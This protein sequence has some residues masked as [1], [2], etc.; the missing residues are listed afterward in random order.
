M[1]GRPSGRRGIALVLAS[2]ILS[3]FL[4]VSFLVVSVSGSFARLAAG[5]AVR[6]GAVLAAASGMEYAAGRLARGGGP[7]SAAWDRRLR[8]GGSRF[9]ARADPLDGRIP[10][11]A[12]YLRSDDLAGLILWPNDLPNGEPDCRDTGIQYHLAVA[13][14]LNNLGWICGVEARRW[15]IPAGDLAG[16]PGEP[17]EISWL[18]MDLLGNRP[19]GGYRDWGQ[20]EKTLLDLGV[21]YT[22]ADVERIRPFVD[23]STE[24]AISASR[25]SGAEGDD[26]PPYIPVN[27][28]AAPIE[29]LESLFRYAGAKRALSSFPQLKLEAG[30]VKYGRSGPPGAPATRTYAGAPLVL[31]PDEAKALAACLADLRAS[32]PLSWQGIHREFSGKAHLLFSREW[33]E[34]AGRNLLRRIW[35]QEKAD[36]AFQVIAID[37]YP[38]LFPNHGG[39]TAWAGRGIDRFPDDTGFPG[40]AGFQLLAMAPYE[41]NMTRVALPLAG[42]DDRSGVY[43]PWPQWEWG[44]TFAP[45]EGASLTIRPQGGA[46]GPPVRFGVSCSGWSVD[47][48]Q[49]IEGDLSVLER[50]DFASQEDFDNLLGGG[51]LRRR[52][53]GTIDPDPPARYEWR[54][55]NEPHDRL[56]DGAL[57][58]YGD[59]SPGTL[60]PGR[61]PGDLRVQARVA[62]L[63]IYNRRSL[64]FGAAGAAGVSH[65][66]GAVTLARREAGPLGAAFYWPFSQ[67]F[68]GSP[69]FAEGDA[70][71]ET[72]HPLLRAPP[73]LPMSVLAWSAAANPYG[74]NALVIDGKMSSFE[75][76]GIDEGAPFG[77]FSLEFWMGMDGYFRL[78]GEGGHCVSVGLCRAMS[79]GTPGSSLDLRVQWQDDSAVAQTSNTNWFFPDGPEGALLDRHVVLTTAPSGASGHRFRLFVDGTDLSATGPMIHDHPHSLKGTW[80]EEMEFRRIGHL[81][82]FDHV[83][84]PAQVA[85]LRALG[86]FCRKGTF[87]SPVYRF[88]RPARL[89]RAQWTGILPH[90]YPES[91]LR[92]EVI[93]RD[94][95]GAERAIVLGASGLEEDLAG[96]GVAREFFYRVHFDCA[97]MPGIPVDDTPVFESIWFSFSRPGRSPAWTRWEAK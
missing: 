66:Y 78:K 53:I 55:D 65:Q 70:W 28:A 47:G 24:G 8:G 5:G 11:N 20:V 94:D 36:I 26:A 37:P 39:S 30:G 82:L 88:D 42:P 56:P 2:G 62:T 13:H 87:A 69:G 96:L 35:T 23:L 85:G 16:T 64:D 63:P 46:L 43:P 49:R 80:L 97:G 12:G 9:A 79:G 67:D 86:R 51:G 34:L 3:L 83:L 18:G 22:P 90:G 14:A 31:W 71:H 10:L 40:S 92:V 68:D 38:Y 57:P 61:A 84:G 72:D 21:G 29:V 33:G 45:Y 89:A 1:P 32:G 6:A 75:C 81:R 50:L 93:A 15:S 59:P 19:P 54:A 52:G 77:S 4:L 25:T 44:R 41:S 7:W 48:A 91:A 17:V 58:V 73:S 76:P 95:A 27:L 60:G 74:A